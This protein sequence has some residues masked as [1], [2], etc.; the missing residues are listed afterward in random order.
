M[1]GMWLHGQRI[2]LRKGTLTKEDEG[3]LDAQLYGWGGKQVT[4]VEVTKTDAR[5]DKACKDPQHISGR[6][7]CRA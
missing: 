3:K 6:R 5:Q 4:A 1:L 7:W 2:S